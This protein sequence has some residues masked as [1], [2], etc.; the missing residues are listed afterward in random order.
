M[1]AGGVVDDGE[2]LDRTRRR[3][4]ERER[5]ARGNASLLARPHLSAPVRAKGLHPLVF[6]Q[7]QLEQNAPV[8]HAHASGERPR[9]RE[10]HSVAAAQRARTLAQ[11]SFAS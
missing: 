4:V 10:L 1:V 5:A 8:V 11:P 2:R 7:A 6:V 9:G 3:A